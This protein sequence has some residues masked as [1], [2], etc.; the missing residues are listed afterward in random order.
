LARLSAPS[1]LYL[2]V[3]LAHAEESDGSERRRAER[4]GE[5]MFEMNKHL[6]QHLK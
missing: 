1:P 3:S 6:A 2:A 4:S 5:G